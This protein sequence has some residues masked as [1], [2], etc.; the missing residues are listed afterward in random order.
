M[1][2]WDFPG[3]P[4]VKTHAS[5]EGHTGSIPGWGTKISWW[6]K[7][8]K[9]KKD[10]DKYNSLCYIVSPCCLLSEKQ[11]ACMYVKL[12]HFAVYLKLTI[13]YFFNVYWG[14]KDYNVISATDKRHLC[15]IN[16]TFT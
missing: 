12:S 7:G 8:K 1:I 9:K 11:F 16:F 15:P 3:G 10:N 14:K 4:V 5:N 2:Y 13:L 6:T